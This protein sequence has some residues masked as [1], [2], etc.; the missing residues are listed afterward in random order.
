MRGRQACSPP[1]GAY[2]TDGRRLVEVV[3]TDVESVIIVDLVTDRLMELARTELHESWRRVD[4][5]KDPA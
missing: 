4:P 2:F 1:L 3:R 5:A